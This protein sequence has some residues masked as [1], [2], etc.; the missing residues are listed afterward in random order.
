MSAAAEPAVKDT[1]KSASSDQQLNSPAI[2]P[3]TGKATQRAISKASQ[4]YGIAKSLRDRA[5]SGRLQTAAFIGRA[6]NGDP[7]FYSRDLTRT[8]QGWRNNFSTN[9]LASVIDRVK[10]QITEPLEATDMLCHKAL[11]PDHPEGSVKARKFNE[12][13]TRTIRGWSGWKDF[14]SGL[15]QEVVTYG[16]AAPTKLGEDWRPRLW[17]YDEV[18]FPEGT[19]QHAG[20]VQVVVFRQTLLMH[21]FMDLFRDK[22]LAEK[23]GYNYA[24]CVK[25]ANAAGGFKGAPT[26]PLEEQDAI[27]ELG[28]MGFSYATEN[29]T[30][31]VRVFHI[32]VRDYSGEIDLWTVSEE[33]GTEIRQVKGAHGSMQ[34]CVTLFTMQTG[35]RK[36]YGSKGLGRLLTNLHTAIERGRNFTADKVNMAGLPVLKSDDPVSVQLQ[37]RYPFMVAPLGTETLVEQFDINWEASEGLDNKLVSIMESI[38]GAFIPPNID[39][40]GSSNTKIEAAQKAE[41]DLAVRQG[42]LSRFANQ[43]KELVDMMVRGMFSPL[44]LREGNRAWE[45]KKRKQASKVLVIMRAAWRLLKKA[46]GSTPGVEPVVETPLADEAAVQAVVELLDAKLTMEEIAMLA[47][48][49]SGENN[50]NEGAA[51]DNATLQYIAAN[52]GNPRIDQNKATSM[53]AK[54]VLG[55]ARAKELVI[56]EE[57]HNVRDKAIRDQTIELSEMMDGNPM[58][59][60][61]YD[62]HSIHRQALAPNLEGLV[63]VIAKDP[64]PPLIVGA[65]LALQHYDMHLQMDTTIPPEQKTQEEGV[66]RGWFQTVT[67]AEA[68]LAKAQEEAAQQAAAGQAQPGAPGAPGAPVPEGGGADPHGDLAT[69]AELALKNKAASQ[70]DRELTLK[71]TQHQDNTTI[72]ALQLQQENARILADAAKQAAAE[73]AAEAER[74]R[75]AAA[76]QV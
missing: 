4:A 43:A 69:A 68:M 31:N 32:L 28:A 1:E 37:L 26:T 50:E 61:G 46:F 21:E 24:G 62:N 5:I 11:P 45:E 72:K 12:V 29:Q 56:P 53:E 55:E 15:A 17:R 18:Y 65:K 71:E 59:V 73:G 74:E 76:T 49:P 34:E 25:T 64:Q 16:N 75:A 40:G 57:D 47:V 30:R 7:P 6:Y 35:N 27:R 10:P 39:Q 8:G 51:K 3:E 54:I 33:D 52:K 9:P 48:S 60:V 2:S 14:L 19:G 41:R 13:A 70:R 66:I 38:A 20:Q 44:V 22:A 23:A 58:P 42:V 67:K 36:F 63:E